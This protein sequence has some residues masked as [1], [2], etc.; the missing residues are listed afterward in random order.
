MKFLLAMILSSFSFSANA[1]DWTSYDNG[2]HHEPTNMFF[3]RTLSGDISFQNAQRLCE[4]ENMRLPTWNEFQIG[5]NNGLASAKKHVGDD[6]SW[7]FWTA[8][9]Q[10]FSLEGLH[11][12]GSVAKTVCFQ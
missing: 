9:A 12:P 1:Q 10:R 8:Q 11:I 6:A 5:R 4:S 3:S 2:L 7:W